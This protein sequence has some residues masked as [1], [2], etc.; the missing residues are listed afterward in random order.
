MDHEK[1]GNELAERVAA[2][3]ER[4]WYIAQSHRDYCGV[5]F[6]WLKEEEAYYYCHFYNVHPYITDNPNSGDR[7]SR[8]IRK[9]AIATADILTY[10]QNFRDR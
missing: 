7:S 4:Y 1:I 3:V 5:G 6:T 2:Y 10:L 9:K 8:T